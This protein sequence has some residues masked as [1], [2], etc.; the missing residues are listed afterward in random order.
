M[1]SYP[2]GLASP[3][4]TMAHSGK[5]P[6]APLT[7]SVSRQ[8]PKL[9]VLKWGISSKSWPLET[10]PDAKAMGLPVTLVPGTDCLSFV[11]DQSQS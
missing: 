3:G 11:N 4:W 6:F 1:L 5:H 8:D 10:S 9:E 2:H 7:L